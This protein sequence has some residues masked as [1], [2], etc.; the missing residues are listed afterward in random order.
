MFKTHILQWDLTRLINQMLLL[1]TAD[2]N[3]IYEDI[4]LPVIKFE[5]ILQN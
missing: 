5:K 4:T 1:Q 3:S 2:I